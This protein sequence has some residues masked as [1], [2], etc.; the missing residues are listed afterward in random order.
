M[1]TAQAHW[2]AVRR[3]L[4]LVVAVLASSPVAAHAHGDEGTLEVLE[5]TPDDT[6]SAVTYRVGLAYANDGD[7]V[8]GAT[9]TATATLSGQDETASVTLADAGGGVYEG[10]V[11]FPRPGRWVVRFAATEPAAELQAS[12]RVQPPPPTTAAPP[13]STVVPTTTVPPEDATLAD[14]EGGDDG[15]PAFLVVGVFVAGVLM[16]AAGTALVL[17]RRREEA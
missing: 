12:F 9:V 5:A 10:T 14:D 11:A 6:G 8:E 7:V 13:V 4:A 17:R 15:P 3:L 2:S 16:L 1:G